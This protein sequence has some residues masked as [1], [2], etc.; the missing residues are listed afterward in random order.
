M[1]TRYHWNTKNHRQSAV[2]DIFNGN[3]AAGVFV[4][5]LLLSLALPKEKGSAA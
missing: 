3:A 4:M 2:G 1:H 5:S